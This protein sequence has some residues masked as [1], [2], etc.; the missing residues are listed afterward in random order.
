MPVPRVAKGASIMLASIANYRQNGLAGI[1]AL[2]EGNPHRR[3]AALYDGMLER[4]DLAAA[5]IRNGD[6]ARKAGALNSAA[7]IMVALRSALDHNAGGKIAAGLDAL[8]D[9]G[10]RRLLEANIGNDI[11]AIDEVRGLIAGIADAWHSMPP[12]ASGAA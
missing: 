2:S 5:C 8:Y 6:I 7:T 1:E 10:I 12:S 4:M 9:Y 11:K 3:V